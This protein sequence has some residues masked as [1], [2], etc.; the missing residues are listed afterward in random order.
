MLWGWARFLDP[1]KLP[2]ARVVVHFEVL[3]SVANAEELQAVDALRADAV[4]TDIRM[5]PRHRVECIEAAHTIRTP[6]RGTG[7]VVSRSTRTP[8]MRSSC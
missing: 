6:H 3:A 1:D 8:P 7:V 2:L 4:L 5:P